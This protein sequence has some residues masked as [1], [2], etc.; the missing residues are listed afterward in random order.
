[1]LN[2]KIYGI[3]ID[4][5]NSSLAEVNKQNFN[6]KTLFAGLI[7]ATGYNRSSDGVAIIDDRKNII[8]S[9][10]ALKETE[11]SKIVLCPSTRM[12]FIPRSIADKKINL[13]TSIIQEVAKND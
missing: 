4:F 7:N 1:M 10:N 8:K 2:S 12:E 9:L 11:A 3:G 6:D 5:F 13:M